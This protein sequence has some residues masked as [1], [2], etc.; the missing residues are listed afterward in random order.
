MLQISEKGKKLLLESLAT[1]RSSLREADEELRRIEN[2]ARS[3]TT[4]A[5]TIV[6]AVAGVTSKIGR[7]FA[8][9]VTVRGTGS[10]A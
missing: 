7:I 2:L 6:A 1:I 5:A 8:R 4:D 3:E 10:D 9:V